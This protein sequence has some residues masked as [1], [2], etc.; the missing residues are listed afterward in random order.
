M[1]VWDKY[2]DM[3]L[4]TGLNDGSSPANAFQTGQ[5]V[6]DA[7]VSGAIAIGEGVGW[8]GFDVATG[9]GIL[10]GMSATIRSGA[11]RIRLACVNNTTDWD[12]DGTRW[13]LDGNL[14]GTTGLRFG[15]FDA[16]DFVNFE[17]KNF[18]NYPVDATSSYYC[19][20][21]NCKLSGGIRTLY[22][23][24]LTLN[25]VFDRCIFENASLYGFVATNQ[26][27]IKNCVFLNC[28][29]GI[30][31]PVVSVIE[32]CVF[33]NCP[34]GIEMRGNTA[35]RVSGGVIGNATTGILLSA[36]NPT[37]DIWKVRFHT[38]SGTAI[39]DSVAIRSDVKRT[40]C[41]F[42]AVGT[43]ISGV[44]ADTV[45]GIDET[46]TVDPCVDAASGDYTPTAIAGNR[47]VEIAIDSSNSEWSGI[48]FT[49]EPLDQA[50]TPDVKKDVW[51]AGLSLK[52]TYAPEGA[53]NVSVLTITV[54]DD[55][56]VPVQGAAIEIRGSGGTGYVASGISESDGTKQLT[57]L[58]DNYTIFLYRSGYQPD[59]IP[60]SVTVLGDT[61][62]TCTVTANTAVIPNPGFQAVFDTILR[63]DGSPAVGAIIVFQTAERIATGSDGTILSHRKVSETC[64]ASGYFTTPL[65][66]EVLYNVSCVDDVESL[67]TQILVTTDSSKALKTYL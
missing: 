25:W 31:N 18:I 51:Y 5:A 17:F 2:A 24:S 52:G 62:K 19:G 3:T 64:D 7:L 65:A 46:L 12:V 33:H 67:P 50:S 30:W 26:G 21:Y 63:S 14:V 15:G 36:N 48:G 56:S 58:D 55:N 28:P 10:M 45:S 11:Q 1:A 22:A 60:F 42:Y 57:L 39:L 37:I 29:V 20:L 6:A 13:G 35:C 44:D 27:L 41:D 16:L 54:L 66:Q 9:S 53:I 8:Y 23:N 38:I 34:I 49:P 61:A 47:S 59:E 43:K 32:N 4:S 40:D